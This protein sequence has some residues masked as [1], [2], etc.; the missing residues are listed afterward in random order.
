MQ[1]ITN[2]PKYLLLGVLCCTLL[3]AWNGDT[4]EVAGLDSTVISVSQPQ[5]SEPTTSTR[6]YPYSAPISSSDSI[7]NSMSR[8]FKIDQKAESSQVKAEIRKLLADQD[9]LYSILQSAGP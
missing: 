5:P 1:F 3:I 2:I 4:T 6:S 7:W 8:E 9:K